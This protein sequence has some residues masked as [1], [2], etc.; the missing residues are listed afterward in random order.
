MATEAYTLAKGWLDRASVELELSATE[1]DNSRKSVMLVAASEKIQCASALVSLLE[2]AV[3][4]NK[5]NTNN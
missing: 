4:E 5:I 1:P 2:F 3:Q